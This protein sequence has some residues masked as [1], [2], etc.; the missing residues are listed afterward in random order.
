M[1]EWASLSSFIKKNLPSPVT[2]AAIAVEQ[3]KADGT[4]L[5][6]ATQDAMFDHAQ[7]AA[8]NW[9]PRLGSD[10]WFDALARIDGGDAQLL[11]EVLSKTDPGFTLEKARETAPRVTSAEWG[12]LVRV[13]LHGTHP[14]PKDEAKPEQAPP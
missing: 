1:K 2:R 10:A 9:P 7:A 4:P 12:E 8:I 13:A 5:S 6:Q 3:A 11:H 14:R